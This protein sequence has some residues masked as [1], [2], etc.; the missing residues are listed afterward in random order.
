MMLQRR[1]YVSPRITRFTTFDETPN[2]CM[3]SCRDIPQVAACLIAATSSCVKRRPGRVCLP[4]RTPVAIRPLLVASCMLSRRVPHHKCDGLQQAGLSQR[5]QT[6][7][8]LDNSLLAST[9][10]TL[11]EPKLCRP[12]R[13]VP[14][15]VLKNPASQGQHVAGP[16]ERS[17]YDQKR[18]SYSRVIT[19]LESFTGS[20]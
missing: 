3:S 5:W 8:L 1:T 2:R 10:A 17:T 11:C 20:V 15:P 7:S 6:W 19:D 9:Y 12:I 16:P 4:W 13:N 18:I 14:Y